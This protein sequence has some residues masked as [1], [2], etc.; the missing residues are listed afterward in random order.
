M[1][2]T[3]RANTQLSANKMSLAIRNGKAGCSSEQ[4][5]TVNTGFALRRVRRRSKGS[6]GIANMGIHQF[7]KKMVMMIIALT[8]TCNRWCGGCRLAVTPWPM[9]MCRAF[10]SL[11]L[12]QKR[13]VSKYGTKKDK[14]S[15]HEDFPKVTF[16]K[17]HLKLDHDDE[18]DVDGENAGGC[19][20]GAISAGERATKDFS[21]N[22]HKQR[23]AKST[24][25]HGIH[26]NSLEY[27][28]FVLNLS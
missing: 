25:V 6:G 11:P 18:N 10:R 14:K 1:W 27:V 9:R 4:A 24:H 17:W 5:L 16:C 2:C 23:E 3:V 8:S 22:A 21:E 12:E 26:L 20:R 7:Q 15:V 28:Q 13:V 19:R